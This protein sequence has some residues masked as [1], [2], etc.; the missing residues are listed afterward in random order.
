MSFCFLYNGVSENYRVQNS[1][2]EAGRVYVQLKIYTFREGSSSFSFTPLYTDGL[3][4][5]YMLDESIRH[6]RG[7]GSTLSILF[8]FCWKILLANNVDSDQTPHY[9]A[10]DLSLLCL[11]MSLLRVSK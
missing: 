11:P 4:H 1:P 10:F 7:V 6:F 2:S 9:V 5:C 3:L 8:Y